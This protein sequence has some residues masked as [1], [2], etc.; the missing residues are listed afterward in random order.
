[1]L[2]HP[3]IIKAMGSRAIML[4][5]L[6]VTSG[7]LGSCSS[8]EPKH[9]GLGAPEGPVSVVSIVSVARHADA[10]GTVVLLVPDDAIF[11]Q[12]ELAGVYVVG[13]DGHISTR[14]VR[15]GKVEDGDY[16]V[17]LG[18]L[19]AGERVVSSYDR[20]LREGVRVQQQVSVT[21]EVQSNE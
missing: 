14:W 15:T 18:G 2:F 10:A 6:A 17:I 8:E 11:R 16:R 21:N 7:I 13:S 19:D 1:M 5:L 3:K 4:Q 20:T 12:G 9:K